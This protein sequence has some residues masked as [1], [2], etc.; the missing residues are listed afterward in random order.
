[1]I[2][3]W[4]GPDTPE[5]NK[6]IA[7]FVASHIPG[8]LRGFS[9]HVTMGVVE[10]ETLLAGVV[11]HNFQPESGVIEL[12]AAS[13]SKRWLTR[14]VL[15]AMF[16]YPFDQ[17]EC[18]MVVLRVSERNAPMIRIGKAYGFQDFVIPRLRGRDEA[19]VLLT[20]TDND[21]R[22]NRFNRR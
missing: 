5:I 22:K 10:G 16:S 21:W 19:E 3:A 14:P 13:T 6:G 17:L 11:F 7:R 2:I 18:Q 15:K 12:S 9:E 8:C 1:L 20:L 4:G